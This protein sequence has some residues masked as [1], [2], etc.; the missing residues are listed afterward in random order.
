M[1]TLCVTWHRL[2]V[3]LGVRR[4]RTHQSRTNDD[5]NLKCP[6]EWSASPADGA[7]KVSVRVGVVPTHPRR[8]RGPVLEYGGATTSLL[9]TEVCTL[10]NLLKS[11]D[12]PKGGFFVGGYFGSNLRTLSRFS[13]IRGNMSSKL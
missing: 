1:F 11:R 4:A 12:P 5:I 6:A 3:V 13:S 2:D 10:R 9:L 8:L 7:G